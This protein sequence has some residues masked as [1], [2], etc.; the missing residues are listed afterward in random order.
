MFLGGPIQA[1]LL[2]DLNC[3]TSQ[4]GSQGHI[5]TVPMTMH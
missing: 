5:G 4:G 3:L 2:S 1:F